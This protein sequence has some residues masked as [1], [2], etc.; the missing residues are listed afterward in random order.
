M[1]LALFDLDH[2][3][4]PIDS[5]YEWSRFL[6][7]SGHVDPIRFASENERFAREYHAGTLDITE[8]LAFQL[9]PLAAVPRDELDRLHEQ[10][11][12]T[13]VLP[14]IRPVARE[15]V[16]H[17]QAAGD[18]CAIVTATNEYVTGP[19]ARAF[20]VEHLIG[21]RVE[22]IDG[23]ITGRSPGTPSFR[24]GKVTRVDEWLAR[25]GH[26]W[27]DFPVSTFYSDS[28]NDLAL[29]E[30]VSRP[31]ATNP[32]ARLARIAGERGWPIRRLFE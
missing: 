17:H 15:L 11:M 6:A 16:R 10:Y 5:D 23:R 32:D 2:T 29:L 12:A 20:G 19:I 13:V 8:F 4:L 31:V 24:E 18:L 27:D 22:E 7:G 30:R 21:A 3:L 28:I 1:N 14:A 9:G 25:L 26:A